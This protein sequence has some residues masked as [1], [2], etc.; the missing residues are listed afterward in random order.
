[1]IKLFISSDVLTFGRE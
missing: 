1:V